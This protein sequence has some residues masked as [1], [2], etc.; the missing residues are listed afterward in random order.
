MHVQMY[1]DLGIN[2]I[3]IDLNDYKTCRREGF[4]TPWIYLFITPVNYHDTIHIT[5][6]YN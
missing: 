3:Y 4:E 6:N 5:V 1:I 2:A